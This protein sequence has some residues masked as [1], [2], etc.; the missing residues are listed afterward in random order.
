[1]EKSTTLVIFLENKETSKNKTFTYISEGKP[2][3]IK[4]KTSTN[5]LI[6]IFF[7]A[8]NRGGK[9]KRR[10]NESRKEKMKMKMKNNT[11]TNIEMFIKD[12]L[13]CLFCIFLYMF[14]IINKTTFFLGENTQKTGW[15]F[16]LL[17]LDFCFVIVVV[18]VIN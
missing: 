5:F 6:K 17:F 4:T 8:Q 9:E 2:Q 12:L 16:C 18:W 3:K 14:V 10:E 7:R 1:M 11:F 13:S 15:L